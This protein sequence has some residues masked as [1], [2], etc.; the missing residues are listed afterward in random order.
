MRKLIPFFLLTM[1]HASAHASTAKVSTLTESF[2]ASGGLAVSA[3]GDIYVANYGEKTIL[4]NGNQIYK[5]TADGNIEEYATG[6]RA[7]TGNTFG[8]DLA[9]YQS[10]YVDNK[11]YRVSAK[12]ELSVYAEGEAIIGPTGLVFNSKGELYIAN[13]N[14]RSILLK[15]KDKLEIVSQSELYACP[16][17]LAVD[18]ND[19]LYISNYMDGNI[20]KLTPSGNLS[21]F[22]TTPKDKISKRAGNGHITFGNQ[23]L[24]VVSNATHQLFSLSLSGELTLLAGAGGKGREDGDAADARFSMPNGIDISPDGKTLYINDADAIGKDSDVSPNVVR[25]IALP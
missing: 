11:I 7:P 20:L 14:H 8:V 10:S 17:G 19:N 22:A 18:D 5:I 3:N 13:C 12:N 6:I 9:L 2:V 15:K 25:M 21:I 23:Q 1:L 4:P 16:A 24:Y